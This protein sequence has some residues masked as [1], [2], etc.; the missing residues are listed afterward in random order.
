[1]PECGGCRYFD[2]ADGYCVMLAEYRRESDACE[3]YAQPKK[4]LFL[5]EEKEGKY[6]ADG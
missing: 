4:W 2:P 5:M 3:E 1:M 6:N